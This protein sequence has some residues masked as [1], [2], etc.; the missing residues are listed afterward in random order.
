MGLDIDFRWKKIGTYPRPFVQ[1]NTGNRT[2]HSAESSK[3]SSYFDLF[4]LSTQLWCRKSL[5]NLTAQLPMRSG[6]L[7]RCSRHL[8]LHLSKTDQNE[9]PSGE[10]HCLGIFLSH[11]I[12]VPSWNVS[13]LSPRLSFVCFSLIS[14]EDLFHKFKYHLRATC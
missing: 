7:P 4:T 5:L 12:S 11:L 8:F 10:D 1:S 14:L 9:S 13:E 3:T 6:K 2:K